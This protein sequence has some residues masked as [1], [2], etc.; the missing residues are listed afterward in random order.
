MARTSTY[1]L[2]DRLLDG[3]LGTLLLAWKAA[4]ETVED[5]AFRL[6]AE[7][8]IKVAVSTVHRWLAIAETPEA[9]AS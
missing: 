6:R 4:D 3:Q 5:M 9:A 2:Y 1:H 8:D 7:H